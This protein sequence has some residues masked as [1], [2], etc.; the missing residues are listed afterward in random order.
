VASEMCRHRPAVLANWDPTGARDDLQN[1]RIGQPGE[2]GLS[3]ASDVNFWRHTPQPVEYTAVEIGASLES[4]SVGITLPRRAALPTG[5]D[6]SF[7]RSPGK[8]QA[9]HAPVRGSRP[10]N[11]QPYS[12]PTFLRGTDGE[13]IKSDSNVPDPICAFDDPYVILR[14]PRICEHTD[15]RSGIHLT[16]IGPAIP[17]RV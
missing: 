12:P 13:R 3:R 10:D 15:N 8:M 2:S 14:S 17:P 4:G 7:F 6:R 1:L 9:H 11:S 5:K 16:S